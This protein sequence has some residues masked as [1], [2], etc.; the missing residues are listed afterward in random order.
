M[1]TEKSGIISLMWE[2]LQMGWEPWVLFDT[3]SINTYGIGQLLWSSAITFPAMLFVYL[4]AYLVGWILTL[5]YT[6]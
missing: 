2:S 1:Q 3:I 4:P 5:I 6:P